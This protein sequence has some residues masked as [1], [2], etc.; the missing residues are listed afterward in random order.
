VRKRAL[1]DAFHEAAI[2]GGAKD[3]G[4]PGFRLQYRANCYGALVLDRDGYNLEAVC[5]EAE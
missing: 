2:S 3:N 5:R 4:K 1:V